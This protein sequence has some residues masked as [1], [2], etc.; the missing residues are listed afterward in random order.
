MGTE[1][2]RHPLRRVAAVMVV[3]L[4]AASVA[5]A[6]APSLAF[7]VG[8]FGGWALGYIAGRHR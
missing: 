5:F 2:V 6:Y 7:A 1:G 3:T 4:L 8:M